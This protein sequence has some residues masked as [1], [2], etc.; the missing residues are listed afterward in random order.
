MSDRLALACYL[1]TELPL[2]VVITD[3]GLQTGRLKSSTSAALV[4][5]AMV[6][7]L[8]LPLVAARLRRPEIEPP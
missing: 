3:I 8:T 2:V 7:V 5:A 4:A 6:S 1:G